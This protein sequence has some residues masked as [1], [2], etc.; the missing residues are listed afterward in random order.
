M[1]SARRADYMWAFVCLLVIVVVMLLT[2]CAETLVTRPPTPWEADWMRAGLAPLVRALGRIAPGRAPADGCLVF[3]VVDSPN[4]A[5]YAASRDRPG[6]GN[7]EVTTGTITTLGLA[8]FR[9]ILAHELAHVALG[10]AGEWKTG[11]RAQAE[12]A[13]ADALGA[14]LLLSAWGREA[15][16]A[17]ARLYERH[18]A[19]APGWRSPVH[20]PLLERAQIAR[21]ACG[22]GL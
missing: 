12:E 8:E 17:M 18:A 1:K 3:G 13:E 2:G 10:H 5:G 14:R 16:L 4:V 15:C 7:L 22:V 19:L 6:C 20:P 21:A 9:A 11:Q